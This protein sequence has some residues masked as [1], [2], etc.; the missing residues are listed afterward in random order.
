MSETHTY[1]VPAMH[2]EHCE[3][4][5]GEELGE[6]PGVEHVDVDLETKRV[7]VTGIDLDDTA[8]RAAI[9]EAGYEAA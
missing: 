7:V 2:C 4:A 1:M 3:R 8:L 5:V 9:E 6:V